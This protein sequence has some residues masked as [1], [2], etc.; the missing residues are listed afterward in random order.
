M[1]RAFRWLCTVAFGAHR[2]DRAAEAAGHVRAL[3][4]GPCDVFLDGSSA[5]GAERAY[6]GQ[7]ADR[8]LGSL[9]HFS[10][11]QIFMKA[12]GLKTLP[13]GCHGISWAMAHKRGKRRK[14]T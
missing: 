11:K 7:L 12:A 1:L 2:G 4:N 5:L 14:Y 10:E 9:M 6:S 8:I 3:R 13:S